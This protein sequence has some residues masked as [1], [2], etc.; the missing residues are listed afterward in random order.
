MP[1]TNPK[2]MSR[3]TVYTPRSGALPSSY[4]KL[5]QANPYQ[6]MDYRQSWMQQFLSKLGFRTNY[7]AYRE[8]LALQAKEYD[9]ALA[10]KAY[11]EQYDSP[12]E[13][14]QR[15]RDAGLNPDLTGNISAGESSALRD[16]GNPAIAPEADDLAI[17][18]NFAGM[19]LQGV[20]MAFGLAGE[21]VNLLSGIADLRSKSIANDNA[22]LNTAFELLSGVLTPDELDNFKSSDGV[23]NESY[24]GTQTGS[25]LVNLLGKR[26]ARKYVSSVNQF[27][28][29][30]KGSDM[31]FTMRNRRAGER[32]AF[33]DK[34]S[35]SG[36]SEFADVMSV[37]RGELSDLALN[38][39][40][41]ENKAAD[42]K[43]Q[44]DAIYEHDVRPTEMADALQ[45][46]Q[47]FN[48]R[49]AGEADT[50]IKSN[51]ARMGQMRIQMR[52]SFDSIVSKL[53]KMANN[54]NWF[55]GIASMAMS[56]LGIKYF[57]L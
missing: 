7:D 40:K 53:D 26:R 34:T 24:F 10:E 45:Y 25:R 18:E 39:W 37:V 56:F 6:T 43:A 35:G 14:V 11:N 2:S 29:S 46:A 3:E 57:G 1:L 5:Q 36:Y 28:R 52:S 12:V 23:V 50:A 15:E 44:N 33:F 54:G 21:G 27:A 32:T 31:E 47:G 48:G 51:E 19:C 55:A 16:D 49:T 8:S 41:H 42:F 9:A 17:A 22:K 13:Q 4:S 30:L 38:L 20:Q